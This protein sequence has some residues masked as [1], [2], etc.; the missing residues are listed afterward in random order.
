MP[1]QS[2]QAQ[3]AVLHHVLMPRWGSVAG[4]GIMG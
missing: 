4:S 1:S 2:E 3:V